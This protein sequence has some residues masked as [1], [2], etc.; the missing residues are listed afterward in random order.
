[1]DDNNDGDDDDDDCMVGGCVVG[2]VDREDR[3]DEGVEL[4]CNDGTDVG[5]KDGGYAHGRPVGA[6]EG[7]ATTMGWEVGNPEGTWVP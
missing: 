4:G 2:T 6:M 3:M 5:E 7:C 1:M